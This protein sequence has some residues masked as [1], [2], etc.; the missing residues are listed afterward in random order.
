MQLEQKHLQLLSKIKAECEIYLGIGLNS[1]L[2]TDIL[3]FFTNLCSAITSVEALEE[4]IF[5]SEAFKHE[6]TQQSVAKVFINIDA[7]YPYFRFS[8]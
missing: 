3:Y 7:T 1:L 8:H 2:I 5:Q 4:V 6:S